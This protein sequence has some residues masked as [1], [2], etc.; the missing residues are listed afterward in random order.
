LAEE[1]AELDDDGEDVDEDEDEEEDNDEEE[2]ISLPFCLPTTLLNLRGIENNALSIRVCMNSS[3]AP[4]AAPVDVCVCVD[5]D[6]DTELD[7][8]MLSTHP[9]VLV[10]VLDEVL[11]GGWTANKRLT[12]AGVTSLSAT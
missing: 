4:A 10:D 5:V 1:D 8:S 7:T 2:E 6:T 12:C 11:V 3:V 9:P